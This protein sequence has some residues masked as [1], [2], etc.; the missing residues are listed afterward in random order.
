MKKYNST[1]STL[2]R[3]F[4]VFFIFFTVA[5]FI[6]LLY[7]FF[8]HDTPPVLLPFVNSYIIITACITLIAY[9]P[10]IYLFTLVC[11]LSF[12]FAKMEDNN[13]LERSL[14]MKLYLKTLLRIMLIFALL[15][16]V[17]FECVLPLLRLKQQNYTRETEIYT[18][19]LKEANELYLLSK[20]AT[21][22]T[23]HFYKRGIHTL[24]HALEIFP[25]DIE[26]NYLLE[27]Y[28]LNKPTTHEPI[29]ESSDTLQPV[30]NINGF[31]LLDLAKAAYKDGDFFSAHY[32]ATTASDLLSPTTNEYQTSQNLIADT[33]SIIEN[34]D[35]S[36][37][38]KEQELYQKKKAIYNAFLQGSYIKA[39]TLI[40]ELYHETKTYS[41]KQL[42]SLKALTTEKLQSQVFFYTDLERAPALTKL[43]N[44]SLTIY[45]TQNPLYRIE[46][47]RIGYHIPKQSNKNLEPEFF[48]ENV[49]LTKYSA[50]HT[51]LF[52]L[53]CENARIISRMSGSDETLVLQLTMVGETSRQPNKYP[54]VLSGNPS[55]P[56]LLFQILPIDM[57]TL[58][59]GLESRFSPSHLSL[60][61]LNSLCS[62]APTFG[63]DRTKY[64]LEIIFRLLCPLVYILLALRIATISWNF[65]LDKKQLR[66]LHIASLPASFLLCVLFIEILSQLLRLLLKASYMYIGTFTLPVAVLL[67]VIFVILAARTFYRQAKM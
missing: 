52:S 55:E 66:F 1:A 18:E 57:K 59:R 37:L 23:E 24:H 9:T 13:V 53:T 43:N 27:S 46:A 21:E 11:T 35:T 10:S 51:P 33:W 31:E 41:D 5:F 22:D 20:T 26:A 40:Q 65:R 16:L 2:Y 67:W 42:A 38:K 34:G 6:L 44:F 28:L 36:T 49:N 48:L 45:G 56:D 32:F 14:A 19:S 4:F 61:S 3:I 62:V 30:E 17:L 58:I 54:T 60:S 63:L 25:S 47:E 39:N 29:I 8:I 50:M 7:Y 64:N 12:L 15:S